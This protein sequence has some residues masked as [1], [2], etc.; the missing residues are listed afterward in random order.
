MGGPKSRSRLFRY[1]VGKG[2]NPAARTPP[3]YYAY[4][5]RSVRETMTR[6]FGHYDLA[7]WQAHPEEWAQF[8]TTYTTE[9]EAFA[10][11]HK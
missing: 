4:M 8:W 2:Q 1:L 3:F 11:M 7:W 9:N 6:E 10:Q 5:Q